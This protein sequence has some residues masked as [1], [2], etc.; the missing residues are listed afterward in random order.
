MVENEPGY[1]LHCRNFT[2]SRLLVETFSQNFGR[3]SGVLRVSASKARGGQLKPQQFVPYLLGFS[4]HHELKTFRQLEVRGV[5]V[6]Q[7]GRRLFCGLYLNELL[8]RALPV[9]DPYPAVYELYE[10]SLHEL[11]GANEGSEDIPLRRF[12]FQFLAELGY[13]LNFTSDQDGQPLEI[14]SGVFY[15]YQP[16]VGFARVHRPDNSQ[17]GNL[18]SGAALSALE[19]PDWLSSDVRSTAKRFCRL[20]IADILG[21]APLRSRELFH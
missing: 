1:V 5:P 16:S 10:A 13:G 14:D 3:V 4:G 21:G 18:F 11:A 15:H 7:Q 12:E 19:N 2:D 6:L 8:Q 9:E 17:R 20:A